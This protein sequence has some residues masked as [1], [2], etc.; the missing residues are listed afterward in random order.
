MDRVTFDGPRRTIFAKP[1]IFAPRESINEQS[2]VARTYIPRFLYATYNFTKVT[3][4]SEITVLL[5]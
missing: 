2:A 5:S 3:D 1:A 4:I